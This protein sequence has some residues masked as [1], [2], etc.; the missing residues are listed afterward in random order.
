MRRAEDNLQVCTYIFHVFPSNEF[1]KR[2]DERMDRP[3]FET[4]AT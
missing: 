4:A 1:K 3:V 2:E